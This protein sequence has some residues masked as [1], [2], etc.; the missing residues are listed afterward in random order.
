MET[1]LYIGEEDDAP[2]KIDARKVISGRTAVI[3]MSGAGKSH[4]VAVLCEEMAKNNLP[5]VIID[6]EGEYSSL[7]EKYQV[8]WASNETGADVRLNRKS[9]KTLAAAIIE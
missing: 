2:F 7:K 4:L 8:V 6:P 5:F 1:Y 3:G 9:A